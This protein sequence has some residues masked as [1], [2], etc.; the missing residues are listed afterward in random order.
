MKERHFCLVFTCMLLLFIIFSCAVPQEEDPMKQA[1]MSI[2]DQLGLP[3]TSQSTDDR[4]IIFYAAELK[5]GDIVSEGSP[6]KSLQKPAAGEEKWL[7]VLDKHPLAKLAHE[8]VY[9]YLNED[10]E[11]VTQEDAEWMP[12]LN[13][14]PLF[15]GDIYHPSFSQIKWKNFELS[16]SETI[17]ASELVVSVPNNCALVVNGNNPER[18][19]DAGISKDKEHMEQF[20]KQFY[21]EVAVRALEYPDNSK[22]DFENAVD[23]LIKGGATRLIIYISSHGSKNQLVMGNS[24]LTVDDLYGILSNYLG[25]KFYVIIDACYSGSFVDGLCYDGLG[26][27]LTIMTA[28]D[29]DRLAYGDCDGKKD[30]NPEDSGGEWTSGFYETLVSYTSS[31]VAWGFIEYI[32]QIHYVELEQVLYKVAFDRA[33]E[34]DCARISWRTVPQYCGWTPTGKRAHSA[35]EEK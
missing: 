23:A 24:R 5:S 26:N 1:A 35:F 17:V 9:I 32:A 27:L 18:Y 15:L 22:E 11:I 16:V 21:G 34:L 29:S 8:V 20:F 3:E 12:F 19:I 31:Q 13:D 6:F 14:Q 10:F 30:P 7:F 28:T 4:F 25:V 2:A 33:W